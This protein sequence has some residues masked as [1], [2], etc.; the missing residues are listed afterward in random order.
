M[1]SLMSGEKGSKEPVAEVQE[2][3]QRTVV[4]GLG[5]VPRTSVNRL[6]TRARRA[7]F[8]AVTVLRLKIGIRKYI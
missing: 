2:V 3:V 4:E 8:Q 1:C 7:L 6:D 5:E